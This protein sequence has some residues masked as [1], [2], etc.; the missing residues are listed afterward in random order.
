MLRKKYSL[1]LNKHF[2]KKGMVLTLTKVGIRPMNPTTGKH[3]GENEIPLEGSIKTFTVDTYYGKK[4]IN[5]L[6]REGYIQKFIL[7]KDDIWV[8]Q[9]TELPA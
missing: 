3:I 4:R 1:L 6:L 8:V 2:S 7:G 9:R 5:V